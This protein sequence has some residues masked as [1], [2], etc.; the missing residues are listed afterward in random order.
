LAKKRL[1]VPAIQSRTPQSFTLADKID[2]WEAELQEDGDRDFILSGLRDGFSLVDSEKID[3][4]VPA[5]VNNY[6]SVTDNQTRKAVEAQIRTEI[7]D[8]AYIIVDKKPVV[9]S[10]LN[11]IPK[12]NGDIRLIHDFSQPPTTGVNSY[13]SKDEVSFQTIQD[14]LDMIEPNWFL[15][16]VDLKSAYRSVGI[17]GSQFKFTGLKWQFEGEKNFTYMSDTRLPFGARKSPAIFHRITQAVRRIMARRGFKCLVVYLDDFLIAGPDFETCLAAYNMLISLLRSL[18]FRIN[19]KKVIDP[20][21]RLTF[22]GVVID[23]VSGTVSLEHKKVDK[24]CELLR[25]F[26]S[27][28]RASRKQLEKL[29]GKLTWAST[30]IPWGRLHTRSIYNTLTKLA[31]PNHKCRLDP[32]QQ[33]LRWWLVYIVRGNNTM[34]IWDERPVLDVYTDASSAAGGAF[35][36]GDWLYCDW[37]LDRPYAHN[38]H[39]NMKELATVREAALRWGATWSN[40]RVRVYTDNTTTAAAINKG[41]STCSDAGPILQELSYLSLVYD[42]EL[43]AIFIPG[44]DNIL[45][46]S[47]SRLYMPGQISRM[48][49]SISDWH[50]PHVPPAGYWLPNHMSLNSMY[51]LSEQI[52]KWFGC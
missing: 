38:L 26:L 17:C 42:F 28:S 40:H 10:A 52:G 15:S 49:S 25:L 1:D 19:W 7:D 33:D 2:L 29:A 30:V 12:P 45:A 16:I 22:L 43:E 27:R 34:R 11:A 21:Q 31:K 48:F 9:V 24:L 51:S 44:I 46:D 13:A 41:T 39:I 35:C 23:T 18:G 37:K 5:E 4:I 32:I 14:A 20:C 3:S 6:G 36:L 8:G 47:I 50:D